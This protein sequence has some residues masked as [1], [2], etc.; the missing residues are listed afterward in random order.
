MKEQLDH[1]C[2]TT[3]VE[4]S[5][6]AKL[7]MAPAASSSSNADDEMEQGHFRQTNAAKDLA[8]LCLDMKKCLRLF[9]EHN[10]VI[11]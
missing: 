8:D 5:E 11:I 2:K 10:Q 3:P 1:V 7:G 9:V 4:K 6:E